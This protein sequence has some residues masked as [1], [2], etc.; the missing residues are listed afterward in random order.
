MPDTAERLN[1]LNRRL[2]ML[3]GERRALQYRWTLAVTKANDWPDMRRA[4]ELFG[5][6]QPAADGV[7]INVSRAT[8]SAVLSRK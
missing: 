5:S 1:A 4:V 2:T 7:R 6:I 3:L 8:A